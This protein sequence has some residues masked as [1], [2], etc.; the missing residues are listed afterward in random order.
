MR[1][2]DFSPGKGRRTD[3]YGSRGATLSRITSG[4]RSWQTVAL[5]LEPNG[6][7][8]AHKGIMDQLLVVVQG[9]GRVSTG[10]SKPVYVEPGSAVFWRGG[11]EHETRAGEDGL[12]AIL[13]EGEGLAK[14]ITMPLRRG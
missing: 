9:N 7:L 12:T 6:V 13:I 10:E 4:P 8:G 14:V 11:E 1:I 3:G 5:F 2:Y